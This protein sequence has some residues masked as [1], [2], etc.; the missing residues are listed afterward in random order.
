MCNAYQI[1]QKTIFEPFR[2]N[3]ESVFSLGLCKQGLNTQTHTN[4]CLFLFKIHFENGCLTEVRKFYMEI[5]AYCLA[6][7]QQA[8]K[9][10]PKTMSKYLPFWRLSKCWDK[11]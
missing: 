11:S 1:K 8:C 3:R 6:K 7:C 4:V 9:G 5:T 2:V 10:F